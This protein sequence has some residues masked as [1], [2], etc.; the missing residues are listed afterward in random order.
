MILRNLFAKLLVVS[1]R[2]LRL[3]V[4]SDDA[5]TAY[6]FHEWMD[7]IEELDIAMPTTNTFQVILLLDHTFIASNEMWELLTIDHSGS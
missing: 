7:S 6:E 2:N 1:F 3:N 5:L 4:K